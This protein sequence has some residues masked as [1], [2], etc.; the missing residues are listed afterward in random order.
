MYDYKHLCI[1]MIILIVLQSFVHYYPDLQ[2]YKNGTRF[3]YYRSLMCMG[4][5]VIGLQVGIKHFKNGFTHPFSFQHNDMDEIQYLFM[6]YLIVDVVKMLADKNNRIDLYIHHILCMI[7]VIIAKNANRYGY[8][9]AMLLVCES[10]SI[11]TG[12][13][14]MAV[15]DGDNILSYHCKRFRKNIINYVRL[16][17]WIIMFTVIMRHTNKMD[18]LLWYNGMVC[19]VVM[20]ALDIYWLKKCD[21]VIDKY[22]K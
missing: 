9:H 16:P 10:I 8:L 4:F 3:N 14:S 2:K 7:S 12:V 21:K 17:M 5:S 6:A 13:D 22:E 1:K 15:E 18:T 11:I 20:I 19:S